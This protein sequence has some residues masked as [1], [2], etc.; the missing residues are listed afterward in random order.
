MECGA[1]VVLVSKT[2]PEYQAESSPPPCPSVA[3][4]NIYIVKDGVITFED[5]RAA[6][7]RAG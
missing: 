3:V 2:S 1:D 7:L 5:L 4:N 6:I